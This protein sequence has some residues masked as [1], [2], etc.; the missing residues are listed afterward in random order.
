MNYKFIVLK[1]F[2]Q[3]E[4]ATRDIKIYYDVFFNLSSFK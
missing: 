2:V 1:L 4:I 3:I